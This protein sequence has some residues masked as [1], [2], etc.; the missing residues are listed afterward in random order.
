[1]AV[2]KDAFG[3][4]AA[5]PLSIPPR[6]WW[7][8]LKRVASESGRDGISVIAA[9]CAFFAMV[10]AFPALSALVALYG[11]TADPATVRDHFAN[12]QGLLPAQAYDLI[13]EQSTR[14][15]E[16][17][18]STLGWSL[19]VSL[20][21]AF[22]GAAKGTK[23]LFG[24][25]NVAYEEEEKRGFIRLNASALAFTVL[26]LVAAVVVMAALVYVPVLF[27]F[28]GFSSAFEV[29][30]RVLRWPLLAGLIIVALAFLY[31]FGPSRRAARWQWLSAGALV[32]TLGWLV[33]SAG[34]ALYVENFADYDAA[35]GSLGAV[36][37]LL[38]WLY[39][40]F[41]IILLGAELNAELE[42]QTRRDT[43]VGRPKPMGTR[44]AYVADN[45]E[46]G[47]GGSS[48]KVGRSAEPAI[49][50]A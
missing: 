17:S 12:L 23:T 4:E 41:Y 5:R 19:A 45:V 24:A 21:L 26:G 16:R 14:I 18:D 35:Y 50:A 6:G 32:A 47:P 1:M 28:A 36:I 29:A 49:P 11:L 25:L 2:A 40:T 38:F 7:Q 3:T 37:V 27:A 9:G 22:W 44:G 15:V 20:G 39:L 13:V 30:V 48:P 46:G 10:A 33:A 43:T 42:L 8:V 34:F 31:R